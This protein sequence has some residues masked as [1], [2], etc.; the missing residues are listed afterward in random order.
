[1]MPPEKRILALFEKG[2]IEDKEALRD[3]LSAPGS[4]IQTN[5]G[6]NFEVID[7]VGKAHV[8][9]ERGAIDDLDAMRA[10]FKKP[11]VLAEYNKGFSFK[12]LQL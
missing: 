4:F 8:L 11:V 1:M 12:V 9:A 6:F 5:K 10:E 3:A 2:A 7:L